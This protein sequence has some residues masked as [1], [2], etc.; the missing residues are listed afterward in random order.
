MLKTENFRV[1]LLKISPCW[2]AVSRRYVFYL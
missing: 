1:R 2:V